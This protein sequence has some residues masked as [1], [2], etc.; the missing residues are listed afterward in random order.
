MQGALARVRTLRKKRG[1]L[2]KELYDVEEARVAAEKRI[3]EVHDE[4]KELDQSIELEAEHRTLA[5]VSSTSAGSF[6]ETAK[7]SRESYMAQPCGT[8]AREAVNQVFY[9]FIKML[10]DLAQHQKAVD[11]Q[12]A[13]STP[14]AAPVVPAVTMPS[15]AADWIARAAALSVDA[16]SGSRSSS[17]D[18]AANPAATQAEDAALGSDKPV[19]DLSSTEL[20]SRSA[21]RQAMQRG[22]S[23][24]QAA[25]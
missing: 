25:A 18:A 21:K 23:M 2:D 12:G 6:L 1:K 11:E 7:S 4:A 16:A 9:T 15:N 19:R 13:Q 17:T 24:E 20:W 8:I 22:E 14:R 3:G 5:L 10:S